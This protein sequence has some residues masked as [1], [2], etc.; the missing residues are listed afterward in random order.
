MWEAQAKAY[1]ERARKLDV[2]YPPNGGASDRENAKQVAKYAETARAAIAKNIEAPERLKLA[3]SMGVSPVELDRMEKDAQLDA[4]NFNKERTSIAEL[5][6]NA[7]TSLQKAGLGKQLTQQPGFTSGPWGKD[8]QTFQQFKSLFGS[9]YEGAATPIE[10]FNKVVN[11]MLADQV[12][13]MGKSGVGRVL[14]SEVQVM[15][16]AIGSLGITEVSNRALFELSMRAYRRAID[17]ERITRNIPHNSTALSQ[18][19][20][21]YLTKNPLVTDREMSHPELLGSKE[22]PQASKGWNPE[23]MRQWGVQNGL[24]PGDPVM[25]NGHLVQIPLGGRDFRGQ[26]LPPQGGYI[27][28]R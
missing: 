14:Q 9:G 25:M 11:D 19:T 24:R 21:D 13:A 16:N 12:K 17:L 3:Q 1:N 22:P 28:P 4:E 26:P 20:M 7:A 10:A 23:Q 15:R 2:L 5:G 6:Q 27:P 18:V 8:F